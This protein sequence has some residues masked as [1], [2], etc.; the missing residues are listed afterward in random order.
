MSN[1]PHGAYLGV[2]C[3]ECPRPAKKRK[4]SEERIA[5]L[6]ASI[7]IAK[8]EESETDPDKKR[9]M[10]EDYDLLRRMRSRY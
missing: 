5:I 7:L 9:Q 3:T 10:R 4:I 2:G 8:K 1:C 6:T